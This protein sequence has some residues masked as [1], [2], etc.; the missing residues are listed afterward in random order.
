MEWATLLGFVLTVAF[1][2]LSAQFGH[3]TLAHWLHPEALVIVLTG[4]L[5]VLFLGAPMPSLF[6]VRGLLQQRRYDPRLLVDHIL[7]LA[8]GSKTVPAHPLLEQGLPYARE[9]VDPQTLRGMLEAEVELQERL[10]RSAAA[11]LRN[12]GR[13]APGIGGLSALL[14]AIGGLSNIASPNDLGP[15]VAAV[16]LSLVY[17]LIIGH[18]VL[19]PLAARVEEHANHSTL[20]GRLCVEGLAGIG[21][22][23]S[24]STLREKLVAFDTAQ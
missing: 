21:R 11:A 13:S 12:A 19:L 15:V 14:F 4:T 2:A 17:G 23:E 18:F 24:P 1:L 6:R 22:G 7:R 9:G 16:L 5:A 10:S 20:C 8:D 3:L